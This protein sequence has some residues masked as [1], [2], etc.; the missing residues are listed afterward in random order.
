MNRRLQFRQQCNKLAGQNTSLGQIFFGTIAT[1]QEALKRSAHQESKCSPSNKF[2]QISGSFYAN[3]CIQIISNENNCLDKPAGFDKRS[4]EFGL[5]ERDASINNYAGSG[6]V[7]SLDMDRNLFQK[8]FNIFSDQR[9]D[10]AVIVCDNDS[11]SYSSS[12]PRQSSQATPPHLSCQMAAEM[13]SIVDLNQSEEEQC[14]E[15]QEAAMISDSDQNISDNFDDEE[16]PI[17]NINP[18]AI[19]PKKQQ[20]E[21]NKSKTKRIRERYITEAVQAV[22]VWRRLHTG[23]ISEDGTT[24]IQYT[25]R[26]AALKVGISKKTLD[27]YLRLIT[28]GHQYGFQFSTRKNDKV[29]QLRSFVTK[30]RAKGRVAAKK[31]NQI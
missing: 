9:N 29:G 25:L 8:S 17:I 10:C 18:R 30:A 6:L 2:N 5:Q 28:L 26:N 14:C 31:L 15:R 27:D 19:L 4:P 22:A 21:I 12:S 7:I 3:S 13:N 20:I 23:V 1:T 11:A 24:L 16:N